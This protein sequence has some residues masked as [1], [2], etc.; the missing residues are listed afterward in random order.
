VRGARIEC[1]ADRAG[2]AAGY[3]PTVRPASGNS[4]PI[5]TIDSGWAFYQV[6][7]RSARESQSKS[8]SWEPL[9][10]GWWLFQIG[11][12]EPPVDDNVEISVFTYGTG[13]V[14]ST[15]SGCA[16]CDRSRRR[17]RV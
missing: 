4:P 12:T 5:E 8:A 1:S 16:R 15:A 3:R 11:P 6:E 14:T 13:V 7:H 2:D 9:Y 10:R 17:D